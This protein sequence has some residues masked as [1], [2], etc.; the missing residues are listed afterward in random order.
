MLFSIFN[1]IITT[2]YYQEIKPTAYYNKKAPKTSASYSEL[3]PSE[4]D[5]IMFARFI[6]RIEVYE[7]GRFEI[8]PI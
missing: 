5:K 1:Y 7:N 3:I 8:Y 2:D 4:P 6:K